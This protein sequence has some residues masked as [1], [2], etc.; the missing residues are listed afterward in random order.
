[1]RAGVPDLV[2][3]DDLRGNLHTHTTD[4]D[5]RDSIRATAEAAKERGLYYLAITDHSPHVTVAHGLVRMDSAG[6]WRPLTRSTT[7]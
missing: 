6:R 2:T 7:K 4:S 5:G 1:L 3:Y